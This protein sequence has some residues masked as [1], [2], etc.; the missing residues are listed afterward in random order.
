MDPVPPEPVLRAQRGERDAVALGDVRQGIAPCDDVA[1]LCEQGAGRR[2]DLEVPRN[3]FRDRV[4]DGP[5]LRRILEPALVARIRDEPGLH[6]DGR[7]VRRLENHE[8][9]ALHPTL[10]EPANPAQPRQHPA[11]HFP[12]RAHGPGLGQVEEHRRLP[13]FHAVEGYAAGQIRRVLP[14]REPARRLAARSA[15]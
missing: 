8:S 12:A 13:R 15:P 9:G 7:D 14:C 2:V 3:P 5:A 1:P 11:A 4:G 6:E 10:V